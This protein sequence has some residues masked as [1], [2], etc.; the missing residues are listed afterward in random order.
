MELPLS[1]ARQLADA[2]VALVAELDADPR[3]VRP[4][5]CKGD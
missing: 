1:I 5:Q 2:W 3:G 4:N